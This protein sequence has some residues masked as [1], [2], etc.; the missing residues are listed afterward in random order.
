M[1]F[2]WAAFGKFHSIHPYEMMLQ[3]FLTAISYR[4]CGQIY[5][6]L[7]N[8]ITVFSRPYDYNKCEVFK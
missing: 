6:E 2:A 4:E 3:V 1:T 8:L 7:G 5:I